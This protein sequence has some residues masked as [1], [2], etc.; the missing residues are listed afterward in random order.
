MLVTFLFVEAVF[1]SL[2]TNDE[3]S[4][5][6]LMLQGELGANA[7][8]AVSVAACK[9]GAAEKEVLTLSFNYCHIHLFPRY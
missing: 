2:A 9:A 4:F 3:C 1:Y 7:I 8:L 6:H 5:V